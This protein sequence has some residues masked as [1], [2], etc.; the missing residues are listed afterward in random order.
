MPVVLIEVDEEDFFSYEDGI[1][2]E[3]DDVNYEKN[4][5]RWKKR[6]E[7]T[8]LEG[9]ESKQGFATAEIHGHATRALPQKSLKLTKIR[10]LP[11]STNGWPDLYENEGFP[12]T[13]MVLRSM[14]SE[15]VGNE[16]TDYGFRDDLIM[17]MI[18]DELDV[19]A[20]NARIVTLYINGEYWGMHSLRESSEQ[21][22][23]ARE[24]GVDIRDIIIEK[25]PDHVFSLYH[26]I[27]NLE[28]S[29][30]A[31]YS[32]L[33]EI[34]DLP[35]LVDYVLAET[36]FNNLDW[37][38][39]NIKTW[40]RRGTDGPYRFIL[41]DM[42][43]CLKFP[44][45]APFSRFLPPNISS[46]NNPDHFLFFEKLLSFPEF[47]SALQA[48]YHDLTSTVFSPELM[49]T[50]LEDLSDVLQDEMDRHIDRWHYPRDFSTWEDS[51]EDIRHYLLKRRL[52]FDEDIVSLNPGRVYPNPAFQEVFVDQL[53]INLKYYRWTSSLGHTL[54]SWEK[55]DSKS[56]G[57]PDEAKRNGVILFLEC[58]GDHVYRS[59]PVILQ[60]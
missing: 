53:P 37:P 14:H 2:V 44:R 34:F 12:F 38:F 1:Y 17:S 40:R 18:Y 52:Y 13:E 23:I 47:R 28:P 36:W 5:K 49:L 10:T 35:N 56:I 22:H 50:D 21:D 45:L 54:S 27:Q 41:F 58:K 51:K 55:M 8:F 20:Q 19:Y 9:S 25:G 15:F 59:Y 11:D 26:R 32:R 39:N 46:R 7:W 16:F 4:G 43:A 48:R 3:G 60:Q 29:S 31:A 57:L 42:D 6:I 24:S 33:S 30:P